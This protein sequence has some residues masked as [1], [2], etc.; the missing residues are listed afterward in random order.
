M[1]MVLAGGTVPA[2][3]ILAERRA[4]AAIP[5][6]GIY[7]IID[8]AL[9]NL[10]NSR[11]NL[12]GILTQYNPSSLI[13]HVGIG[14]PWDFVGRTRYAKILSPYKGVKDS[15]WYRGTAD[16]VYQNRNFIED[17]NPDYVLV[18]SAE[19]IYAM[20]YSPVIEL[21]IDK[22]ADCTIVCK[23]LPV[24]DPSRFGILDLDE[25]RKVLR[26]EEKPQTPQGAYYSLGI[27]V[28]NTDF[29]LD[30]LQEDAEQANSLHSFAYDV[31]PNLVQSYHVYAYIFDGV[32][33]YC[34]SIAEYWRANMNLL[35]ERPEI[36]LWNWPVRTNL[37]DG[38]IGD[39]PPARFDPSA[40]IV[41]SLI[42]PGCLIQGK[43]ERSILSPG[44][45]VEKGAVVRDSVV[46]HNTQIEANARVDKAILDKDVWIQANTLIGTEDLGTADFPYPAYFTSGVTVLGKSVKIGEGI[47]IGRNCFIYPGI[48]IS[49]PEYS[50]IPSGSSVE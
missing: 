7:R 4:K 50:E 2:L 17:H 48:T 22:K 24:P 20:D 9:S 12:V 38:N 49:K 46:M 42:S 39:R 34:G 45:T 33:E 6:G 43:V 26:Y 27:Y 37:E 40:E 1:A 10:M 44:V 23:K 11:I 36:D 47:R 5:F 8:F 14:T 29:L 32:W 15:D 13:G 3:R 19:H 18:L 28:F 41:N 25:D 30:K 16:A 31:I 21:H 35:K